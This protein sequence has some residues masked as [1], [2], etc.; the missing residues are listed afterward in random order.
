M[1]KLCGFVQH[2]TH[3]IDLNNGEVDTL[4]NKHVAQLVNTD[5]PRQTMACAAHMTPPGATVARH[6]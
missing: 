2:L 5:K 4:G 6:L 1:K 3:I